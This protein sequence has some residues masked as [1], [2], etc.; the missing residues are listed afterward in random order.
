VQ[1]T[2]LGGPEVAKSFQNLH[3]IGLN[4]IQKK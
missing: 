2:L 4:P 3:C 1:K